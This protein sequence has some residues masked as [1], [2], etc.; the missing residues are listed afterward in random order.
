MAWRELVNQYI[1]S[2]QQVR[3]NNPGT[4]AVGQVLGLAL[5]QGMD[6]K[7]TAMDTMLKNPKFAAKT[8]GL[9]ESTTP[10]MTPPA[11]M[12]MDKIQYDEYGNPTTVYQNPAT[13]PVAGT[14]PS[15]QQGQKALALASG[16]RSG[17]VVIGREFGE[18]SV[19]KPKNMN[20]ALSAIMEA[21]FDPSI[22]A[23]ELQL[24]DVVGE[25]KVKK[26]GRIIQ[27]LRNGKYIYQDTKEEVQVK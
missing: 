15:W 7:K 22:F 11:G 5:K 6:T 26:T 25:T 9:P 3:S 21:G 16:L 27:K 20:E 13:N 19:Y 2:D 23:D 1:Q 12:V 18:P 8:L 24:Y 10:S 4:Q 14:T 17:N